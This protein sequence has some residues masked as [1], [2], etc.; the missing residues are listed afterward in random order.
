LI[1]IDAGSG[2]T[3]APT[4]NV[5]AGHDDI[6]VPVPAGT[7][8]LGVATLPPGAHPVPH[9]SA[10]GMPPGRLEEIRNFELTHR[11]IGKILEHDPS[12]DYPV[13]IASYADG[14]W[15]CN[16]SFDGQGNIVAGSLP[17][18]VTKIS[19]WTH[20]QV[21]GHVAAR[22]LNIG[23]PELAEQNPPFIFL[24]GHKDFV[25]T[26][27][28]VQNLREYV[29]RGGLIWGDNALAGGGSRF[30][31][32]FRREMKRVIPSEPFQPYA[33]DAQIFHGRYAFE[34]APQGM[35]YRRSR[36]SM[37]ISMARSRFS[38][39]RTTTAISA[40]CASCPA[41]RRSR[42]SGPRPTRPW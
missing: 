36:S 5:I 40:P 3:P 33:T 15:A 2:A 41:T 38:T 39:R 24:T 37:S 27:Q 14:D 19:E 22:P 26:P 18:L 32:A 31:V 25:L 16:I 7:T 35:N 23:G 42:A 28:E 13:Y 12:C 11:T 6:H 8:G 30:D 29:V 34:Q 10:K 9:V 21:N 1:S 4:P 17:N 20:H